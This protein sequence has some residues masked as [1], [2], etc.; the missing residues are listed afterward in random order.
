MLS[1]ILLQ[2]SLDDAAAA[3]RLHVTRTERWPVPDPAPFQPPVWTA[4]RF[5]EDEARA[6][7]VIDG[8]S[9]ALKPAWYVNASTATTVYVAFRG[10][11]FSY[12]RGDATAR[13]AV[14]RHGLEVG[15]PAR[16][17]DWAE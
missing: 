14:V 1:G 11:L 17:L 3:P 9:R 10:R 5:E 12:A 7:D 16:Q 13:A 8:L 4:L 6:W 2:E 15:V